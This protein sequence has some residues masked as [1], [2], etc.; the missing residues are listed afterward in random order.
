LAL[1]AFVDVVHDITSLI[2]HIGNEPVGQPADGEGVSRH[3]VDILSN[4]VVVNHHFHQGCNSFSAESVGIASAANN[5]LQEGLIHVAF[6]T[7]RS[8]SVGILAYLLT[9]LELHGVAL[10]AA[11]GL[12]VSHLR[13]TENPL[14]PRLLKTVFDLQELLQGS[15]MEGG[16][17]WVSKVGILERLK[18]L[19][20]HLFSHFV[21][22]GA[23]LDNHGAE[24]VTLVRL[25]QIF[26]HFLL[27]EHVLSF[28][29]EREFVKVFG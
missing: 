17:S 26:E 18:D 29:G 24:A 4:T 1:V 27:G 28:L 11:V 2:V 19:R 13:N 9:V 15:Q 3:L 23:H 21:V 7:S 12:V 6:N 8:V 14:N 22:A 16:F 5:P 20:R 25:H 10:S